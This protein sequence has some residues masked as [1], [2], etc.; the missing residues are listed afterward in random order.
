MVRAN[1]LEAGF[2]AQH[3][4]DDLEP[5]GTPYTH[6][7]ERMRGEAESKIRGRAALIGFSG[8]RADTRVEALSGG[9]KAR[10]LMGLATFDGPQLLILDEPTNHLDIDSRGELIEAI[11]DYEGACIIVSHD[12]RLLEACVDRLWLVAGGTV[13]PF[14][15]DVADYGR[16][17]LG[18]GA[19]GPQKKP[20]APKPAAAPARKRDAGPLKRE[21]AALEDKMTR[22]QDLLRR[23][24]EALA[25]AGATGGDALKLAELAARRGDLERALAAAE[26]AWLELSEEAEGA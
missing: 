13:K 3:Q 10:L 4:V 17:V 8:G 21:L 7:A 20:A 19:P 12:R 5:G 26:E 9:E 6:V 25:D 1:K 18:Q 11:N 14:D 15:G 2:F 16:F 24:D 23:V 22:F